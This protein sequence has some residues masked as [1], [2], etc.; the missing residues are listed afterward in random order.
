VEG[1]AGV[2]LAAGSSSRMGRPKQLLRLGDLP[3]LQHVVEAVAAA[4]LADVVVVLGHE[5]SA[6]AGALRL[7][8]GV[9]AVRNT[10]HAAGLS[11]SLRTG[12]DALGPEVRAAV[13]A[14]GDQPE[15]EAASIRA[16]VEAYRRTGSRVVQASYR[17]VPDHPVLLDRRVW[18]EV[19][20]VTGDRG[21]RDVL[22]AH[23]GWLHPVEL[24]RDPPKDVDT[25][26][27]YE[28]LVGRREA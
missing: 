1:V 5:A 6:V 4:G 16:V 20:A 14:L 8:G 21:A 11:T 12:L 18:P 28:E 27:D 10:E 2:V 3:L 22:A 15:L 9:R 17:G 26:G 19:L 25:W 24:D 13:V 23:P 7:P